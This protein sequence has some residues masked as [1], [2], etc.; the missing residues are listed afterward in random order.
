MAPTDVPE[1]L[2]QHIGKGEIIKRIWRFV[3]LCYA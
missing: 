2:D 3:S 1:L